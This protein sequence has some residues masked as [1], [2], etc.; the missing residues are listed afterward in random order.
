[1]SIFITAAIAVSTTYLAG[2]AIIHAAA[3]YIAHG[4]DA[5]D[6]DREFA[7]AITS[8]SHRWPEVYARYYLHRIRR[9]SEA[10]K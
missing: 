7:A 9:G 2:I 3:A 6:V 1:M 10:G 8:V 4:A 5:D